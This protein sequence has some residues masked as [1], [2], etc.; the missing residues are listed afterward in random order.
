MALTYTKIASFTLTGN[1]STIDFTSIPATYTHLCFKLNLDG[2]G[3]NATTAYINYNGSSASEYTYKITLKD[4]NTTTVTND[5]GS[6][7]PEFI[8]IMG[9]GTNS[10][11]N[12]FGPNEKFILNYAAAHHKH[13]T[14]EFGTETAN[15]DKWVG[16]FEGWWTN[17]AAIN[18][19][20]FTAVSANWV[21]GSTGILYGILQA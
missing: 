6:A 9:S 10:T 21:A 19:V 3:Y 15:N 13:S 7:T 8:V 17:T 1:Q 2:T 12:A 18:R 20:T 14:M 5:T 11:A 4:G 16:R